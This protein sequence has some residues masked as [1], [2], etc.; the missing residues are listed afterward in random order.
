MAAYADS[1]ASFEFRAKQI[2]LTDA[3]IDALADND[4]K[5]FKN[6]AFAV[7]G[8]PGQLDTQRFQNLVDVVCPRGA[9]IGVHSA[10]R[11]LAYEALTV[12]V[13]A[14][15]QRIEAP[16]EVGRK[17]PAQELDD[18]LRIIR[19]KI[20]G[21]EIVGDYEPGHSVINAFSQM[22]DE[23]V[24]KS[25]PLSNFLNASAGNMKWCASCFHAKR[26]CA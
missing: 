25:F 19:E 26:S 15:K 16:D 10:L 24:L 6:L 21:F 18:R 3:H 12:A 7:N 14:I 8:Q 17:L 4:I 2:S 13:A 23:G 20:T 22:L 11:Q 1:T 9:S 5:S